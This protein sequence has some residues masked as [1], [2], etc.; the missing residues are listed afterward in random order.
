MRRHT[1]A[2]SAGSSQRQA[3]R[4]GRI[5]RGALAT[6][7]ASHRSAG[8]SAPSSARPLS[9]EQAHLPASVGPRRRTGIALALATALALLIAPAAQGEPYEE[10]CE[11]GGESSEPHRI[12]ADPETGLFFVADSGGDSVKVFKPKPSPECAELLLSF[13][14]PRPLGIAIDPENGDLYTT[15]PAANERQL[16]TIASETENPGGLYNLTFEGKT[17]GATGEGNITEGSA[18]VTGAKASE[19][20]FM[21]GQTISGEGIPAGAVIAVIEKE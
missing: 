4:L 20:E 17:T 2:P 1:K 19:G 10:K 3:S 13:A 12:A 11:F 16:V 21:L 15:H 7:G 6:R 8:S 5:F 18:V 14:S 9:A